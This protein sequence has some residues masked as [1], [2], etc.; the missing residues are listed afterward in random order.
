MDNSRK[1]YSSFLREKKG[2]KLQRE[3]EGT[4]SPTF[5]VGVSLFVESLGLLL[6]LVLGFLAVDEVKSLGLEELVGLGTSQTGKDLLG[7][8][9]LF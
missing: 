6:G 4:E 3:R 8:I 2:R 9:V 7:Q 5:L 1:R